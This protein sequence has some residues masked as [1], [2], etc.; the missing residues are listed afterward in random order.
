MAKRLALLT[1]WAARCGI[2]EYSR[3]LVEALAGHGVRVTVLARRRPGAACWPPFVPPAGCESV[4][5]IWDTGRID[6]AMVVRACRGAGL[7]ALGIQYHHGFFEP[8]A[9]LAVAGHCAQAGLDVTVTLHN[10]RHL[11]LDGLHRLDR[12]GTSLLVHTQAEWERLVDYGV[13]NVSAISIGTLDVADEHE[14][15][16]R[17]RLG[18]FLGPVIGTFGFLRPHKGVR[19]LIEAAAVLRDLYPGV[20]LLCLNALYPAPDSEQC[21]AECRHLV[22]IHRLQGQVHLETGFRDIEQTVRDLHACDAIILPYHPSNEGSSASAHVALAARRPLLTTR[23]TVFKGIEDVAYPVE[24]LAP[25]VLAAALATV[26]SSP[27]LRASLR[28]RCE[29]YLRKSAWPVVAGD[30]LRTAMACA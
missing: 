7:R 11:D 26:L 3:S 20:T 17:A 19:E 10:S 29:A 23:Q 25:P 24:S 1:S 28:G 22:T 8:D 5:E 27:L 30:Y 13:V 16:A 9:L 4:Q 6:P 2:A 15:D 18:L 21:L 14:Q 12:L